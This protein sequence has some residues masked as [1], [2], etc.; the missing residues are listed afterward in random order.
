MILVV[1]TDLL[2]D[3]YHLLKASV[4]FHFSEVNESWWSVSAPLS[5]VAL[6][7]GG[8]STRYDIVLNTHR[9]V[10]GHLLRSFQK[11]LE[12]VLDEVRSLPIEVGYHARP[13]L[14]HSINLNS[15]AD[16]LNV[17]FDDVDF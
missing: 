1:L 9:E 4:A 14:F 17:D 13:A 8:E 5:Y 11:F 10:I 16:Q 12:N 15:Y 7:P 3:E 6:H 2:I